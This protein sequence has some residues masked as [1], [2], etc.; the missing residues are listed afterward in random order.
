MGERE[1]KNKSRE[2]ERMR[3]RAK[4]RKSQYSRNVLILPCREDDY[5]ASL[6]SPISPGDTSLECGRERRKKREREK[7]RTREREKERDI[8]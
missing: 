8:Q 6:N 7:E 3:K 1:G 5:G 2:K 4:E